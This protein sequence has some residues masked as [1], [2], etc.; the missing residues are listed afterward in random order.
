MS[1]EKVELELEYVQ[2]SRS[3]LSILVNDGGP[4]VWL[5][6]SEIEIEEN[7]PDLKQGDLITV[8]VPEWLATEEGLV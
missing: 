7:S 2:H 4:N 3:R 1:D 6:L 5:P 8:W